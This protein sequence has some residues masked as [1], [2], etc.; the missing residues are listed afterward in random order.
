NTGTD[1]AVLKTRD[2]VEHAGEDL[3]S[4]VRQ[5]REIVHAIEGVNTRYNRSLIEQAAI[6]GGL[7]AE[8]LLDPERT[9]TVIER[10][11]RRLDRLADEVERGWSG[12]SDGQ[13]GL[14]FTRTIRGVTESHAIDAQLL[15]SADARKVRATVEKLSDLYGGVAK[16]TRKDQSFDIYGPS[17]LFNAINTVGRKG[18]SLQRYKGLGEMNPGQLW[19]TTLDPNVRTLLQVQ[20][21]E[22]D[23][24]DRLFSNLMGDLVEPRRDFIQ[25][26][27]L[28]VANLDV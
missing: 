8:A 7:D 6:V 10:V 17:S 20:I 15:A 25:D 18:I 12:V 1:E 5:A 23:D 22:S 16:L 21:K 26:N 11:V 19:E 27:A 3:L 14:I 4:I 13:G 28:S 2:G 24:H 9:A